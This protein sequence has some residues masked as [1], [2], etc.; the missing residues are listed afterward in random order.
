MFKYLK[1]KFKEYNSL[2]L[3][4]AVVLNLVAVLGFYLFF[5]SDFL[6]ILKSVT[7]T[8]TFFY[9]L[10]FFVYLIQSRDKSKKVK[11]FKKF[12]AKKKDVF[13]GKGE[14]LLKKQMKDFMVKKSFK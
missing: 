9:S 14:D 12:F 8:S 3:L 6:D 7:L 11:D 10:F 1:N 2:H 5:S 4:N 13:D